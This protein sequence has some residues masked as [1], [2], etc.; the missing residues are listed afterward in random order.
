MNSITLRD[1]KLLT[2]DI[3]KHQWRALKR[4]SSCSEPCAIDS[5][6][7]RRRRPSILFVFAAG[8]R[9]AY[10]LQKVEHVLL[11][12]YVSVLRAVVI[13]PAVEFVQGLR[14]GRRFG[15]GRRHPAHFPR[16][17]FTDSTSAYCRQSVTRF[18]PATLIHDRR[19]SICSTKDNRCQFCQVSFGPGSDLVLLARRETCI[20]LIKVVSRSHWGSF[21]APRNFRF[22]LTPSLLSGARLE[23]HG[24]FLRP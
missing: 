23:N 20:H 2:R 7:N 16:H 8:S 22:C 19:R 4:H 12:V 6:D 13:N 9:T 5:M 15:R 3:S 14:I 1:L 21:G 24:E 17:R 10:S 11:V 18:T